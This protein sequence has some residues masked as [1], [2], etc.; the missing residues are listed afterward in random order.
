MAKEIDKV[1]NA[2]KVERIF[3]VKFSKTQFVSSARYK[4]SIDLVNTVLEDGK[5]YSLE[6][7]DKLIEKYMK[8][9]VN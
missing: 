9:K 4:D 2:E 8:G 6:E 3:E 1:E 7:V 5:E